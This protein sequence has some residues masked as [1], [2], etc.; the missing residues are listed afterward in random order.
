MNPIHDVQRHA[1]RRAFRQAMT[2]ALRIGA[3]ITAC[4]T[5]FAP[6]RAERLEDL[7]KLVAEYQEAETAFFQSPLP[8][9]P[10][11]ADHIRRY[12]EWPGWRYLP[13]FVDLAE[14][15]PSDETAF[16]SCLWVFDRT[17][18]VGN[19]EG[20]MF[21]A[22]QKAWR[23]IAAHH[24]QREELPE[25]CMQAVQYFGPAQEE[26]LRG[27]LTR[28]VFS[29]DITGI[30]TVSLAE[31]LA[32]RYEY[33]ESIEA[34]T[35]ES[36]SEFAEYIKGRRSP[37]WGQ[38]LTPARAARYKAESIELFRQVLDHYADVPFPIS[39]PYFRRVANLG[40]KAER[41][42]HALEHLTIGAEAPDVLGQDIEGNSLKLRD[43]RGRVVLLSFWFTGCGPCMEMI[44]KEQK[45]VETFKDR[46]FTL[47]A[48]CADADLETAQKTVKE[49]GI[50][51]TCWFDGQNGPI[52]RDY[53]VQRWPT[54]YLLDK[55]GR[56]AAKNLDRDQMDIQIAQLLEQ[57]E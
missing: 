18:N 37:D 2:A 14:A 52:V 29:R 5:M 27:L 13:R 25:L 24:T 4:E 15:N 36:Q 10:T 33:I 44:P 47:L 30:A 6:V 23:I 51:W 32:H 21:E 56:I 1:S 53:N 12:E 3:M 35:Q 54:F 19:G 41:S 46:P 43:Y 28:E 31:L 22:D 49:H 8:E 34:S 11:A 38:A 20:Q 42:L 55:D 16:R 50:D 17:S 7:E 45:L 9:E 40:E 39:M 48:V 26:F 57:K